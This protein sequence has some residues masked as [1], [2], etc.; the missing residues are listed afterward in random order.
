[1][2]GW[3]SLETLQSIFFWATL[4]AAIAGGVSITA[5]FVSAMVGYEVADLIQTDADRRIAEA[6]A[7]GEE[8]KEGVAKANAEV[9]KA[10]EAIVGAKERAAALEKEAAQV[11]AE[12]ER[13][14]QQVA[15]RSVSRSQHDILV[16]NLRGVPTTVNIDHPDDPESSL[17]AADI[18]Q[19]LRDAGW[20]VRDATVMW[21]P[22]PPMGLTVRHQINPA[23]NAVYIP[24]ILVSA[25]T[26]AG[27]QV[28]VQPSNG[29]EL[30]LVVGIKPC[31]L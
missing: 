18:A 31:Q 23:S 9:A 14:K 25:L 7:R 30:T 2:W 6:N 1:M 21:S 28:A 15:W 20:T 24:H 5:A 29:N 3:F 10:N 4:T 22:H 16:A 17:F 11:R 12:Y 19:S 13:L 27:F 26:K 8:A